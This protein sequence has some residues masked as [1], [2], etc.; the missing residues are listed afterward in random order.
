[1]RTGASIASRFSLG[2][3]TNP[4]GCTWVRLIPQDSRT[5]TQSQTVRGALICSAVEN[6]MDIMEVI[7]KVM[8][9]MGG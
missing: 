9:A 2:K 3:T 8:I 6:R 7:F 5:L 1:M 4:L